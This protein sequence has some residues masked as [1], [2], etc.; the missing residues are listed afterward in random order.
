M[1]IYGYCVSDEEMQEEIE[2]AGG[3]EAVEAAI[4]GPACQFCGCQELVPAGKLRDVWAKAPRKCRNEPVFYCPSC[5]W[6]R[7]ARA[8]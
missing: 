3:I 1:A 8:V 5:N 6:L 2:A 4:A 7:Q